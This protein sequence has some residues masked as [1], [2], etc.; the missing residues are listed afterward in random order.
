MSSTPRKLHVTF[1]TAG[2]TSTVIVLVSSVS[3]FVSVTQIPIKLTHDRY[4]VADEIF[5]GGLV[6]AFSRYGDTYV[7]PL[8]F[9]VSIDTG[10]PRSAGEDCVALATRGYTRYE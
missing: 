8:S 10:T 3:V 4:S 7:H 9:S 2:S 6:V 1:W 5:T